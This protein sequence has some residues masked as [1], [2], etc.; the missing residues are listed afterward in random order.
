M[1]ATERGRD[2]T[3]PF[4]FGLTKRELQSVVEQIT[5]E[6]VVSFEASPAPAGHKAHLGIHAETVCVLFTYTS[7]SGRAR[8]AM[9]VAKRNYKAG[10]TEAHHYRYLTAQGMPVART[11]GDITDGEGR[12]VI[13]LEYL[14]GVPD[15]SHTFLNDTNDVHDFLALA[16]R[17]N[18]VRPSPEYA[19]GLKRLDWL[20]YLRRWTPEK[21]DDI[22]TASC[23]GKLGDELQELCSESKNTVNRLPRLAERLAEMV[24]RINIGFVHG[25]FFPHHTGRRLNSGEM[26][27]F[28]FED[29]GLA[30]WCTDVARWLGPPDD[31]LARCASRKDLA[32]VYLEEYARNG[33]ER[34][35]PSQLLDE[36]QALWLTYSLLDPDWWYHVFSIT[37]NERIREQCRREL[38]ARLSDLVRSPW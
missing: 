20:A 4:L 18:C 1:N 21:L 14:E 31:L 38:Y 12:E 11:Y 9:V 26:V 35:A 17:F 34:V 5:G 30:P 19:D 13:F 10:R 32:G 25:D 27:A 8:S 2:G 29:I 23:R 22:W 15:N 33:G 28:D 7:P 37:E 24:S 3:I 6:S 36:A 16:A